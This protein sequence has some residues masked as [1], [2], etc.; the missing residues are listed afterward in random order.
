VAGFLGWP[1]HH[2]HLTKGTK[3][4]VDEMFGDTL[5]DKAT[6]GIAKRV[7]IFGAVKATRELI[8]T[9][10]DI[11]NGFELLMSEDIDEETK[12]IVSQAMS[13]MNNADKEVV[14]LADMLETRMGISA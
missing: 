4:I 12:S 9:Y 1:W 8:E 14:A 3:M 11:D 7:I 2:S 10:T 5:F 6:E 13:D